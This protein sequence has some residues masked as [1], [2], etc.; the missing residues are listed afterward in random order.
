[1][2]P[3]A[4][5]VAI[6]LGAVLALA[7]C[8]GGGSPSAPV[9]PP[10]PSPAAR[11]ALSLVDGDGSAIPDVSLRVDGVPQAPRVPGGHVFDL[12]PGLVGRGLEADKEGF[13][14]HQAFVPA[15]DRALDL[16]EVPRDG[17]KEWIRNLLY[18]GVINRSGR[19]A[20]L[21]RPVSVVRGESVPPEEWEYALPLLRAAAERMTA[22]TGF[23]FEVADQP[24][25]GTV[26]YTV[27]LEGNLTHLGYFQWTGTADTIQRGTI[28][29]RDAGRMNDF[30]LVLH[31]LT[32]GFG[33]SHSDRITDVMH[34]FA[35]AET[36]T[37]REQSV[38]AAVRR[39]PPGTAYEDD[40]R[41]ATGPLGHVA[42]SGSSFCG[43]WT[44]S[45]TR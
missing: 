22:V 11:I 24:A 27:E 7:A 14:L 26:P 1:M 30:S 45:P 18:D 43:S 12:E 6:A 29:F 21:T 35:F 32:H 9:S 34:P 28:R 10:P 19:L 5:R 36:H 2:R 8:G 33:L 17:S 44:T 3:W 23:A 20:R 31:E 42:A 16:F 4:V 39:R 15:Q 37:A 25:I 13:L 40:V 41:G 38:I